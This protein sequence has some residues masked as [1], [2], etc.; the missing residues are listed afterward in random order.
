MHIDSLQKYLEKPLS[1]LDIQAAEKA[2]SAFDDIKSIIRGFDNTANTGKGTTETFEAL[3]IIEIVV[4]PAI[5]R[6][7]SEETDDSEEEIIC[8]EIIYCLSP[9][10]GEETL[11]SEDLWKQEV[12]NSVTTILDIEDPDVRNLMARDIR[13]AR[14]LLEVTNS[15]IHKSRVTMDGPYAPNITA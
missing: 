7:L 1:A 6:L 4:L 9:N 2:M 8:Q 14:I 11:E 5:D 12:L 15:E 3:S 13:D 10:Q